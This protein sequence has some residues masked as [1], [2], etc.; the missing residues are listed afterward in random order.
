MLLS[1]PETKEELKLH[2]YFRILISLIE[3]HPYKSE[4]TS[5]HSSMIVKGGSILS[6][7]INKIFPT[8]FAMKYAQHKGWQIHSEAEAISKIKNK[9]KI[10]GATIYNCRLTKCGIPELSKPCFGCIKMLRDFEMKKVVYTTRQGF[11]SEKI[12]YIIPEIKQ[13]HI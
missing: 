11:K 7:G 10:K 8:S 5:L 13:E 4:L 2:T 1:N 3:D 12:G 9:K 6:H